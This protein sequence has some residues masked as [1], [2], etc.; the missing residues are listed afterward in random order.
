MN[1]R[2]AGRVAAALAGV[3]LAATGIFSLAAFD[4]RAQEYVTGPS[5]TMMD[6][7]YFPSQISIPA[8][9]GV[10]VPLSNWS[11]TQH[12][13]VVPALGVSSGSVMPGMA[14]SVFLVTPAGAYEFIC[15]IPGH[16]EAGMSGAIYAS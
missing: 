6:A 8:D 16:K 12:D 14:S 7:S 15:S 2:I 13:F 1:R 4:A 5:V 11:V 10:V 3:A 9:T